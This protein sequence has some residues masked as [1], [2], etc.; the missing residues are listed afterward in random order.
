MRLNN[1]S[2]KEIQNVS[3]EILKFVADI[4]DA[5]QLTY[6][7]AR[8]TLL[9]AVRHKDIIPG[10]TIYDAYEK[11]KEKGATNTVTSYTLIVY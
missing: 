3:L 9:G 5:N 8:G 11:S 10:M 4:C 1:L 2:M 6:S 7:L